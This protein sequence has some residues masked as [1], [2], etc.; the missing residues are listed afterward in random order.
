MARSR[1]EGVIQLKVR[2]LCTARRC[3]ASLGGDCDGPHLYVN[4]SPTTIRHFARHLPACRFLRRISFLTPAST[5]HSYHSRPH[6][7]LHYP[8]P[9]TTGDKNN[10]MLAE[11]RSGIVGTTYPNAPVE[12]LVLYEFWACPLQAPSFIEQYS[13]SLRE[14]TI[15][16]CFVLVHNIDAFWPSIANLSVLEKLAFGFCHLTTIWNPTPMVDALQQLTALHSLHL[17]SIRH[18]ATHHHLIRALQS[19]RRLKV[20]IEPSHSLI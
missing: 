2:H 5:S 20:Q 16:G 15:L 10:R 12:S 9:V 8:S 3:R 1:W 11:L 13:T 19:A 18:P 4:G 17:R 14:L 6:F 7:Q